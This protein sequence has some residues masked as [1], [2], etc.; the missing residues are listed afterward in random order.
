MPPSVLWKLPKIGFFIALGIACMAS[1]LR[2]METE[3]RVFDSS[4]PA[5]IRR[6]NPNQA[7]LLVVSAVLVA[8]ALITIC[9]L[10]N[11]FNNAAEIQDHIREIPQAE[12]EEQVVE[13]SS[14]STSPQ[15][16]ALAAP[17][18]PDYSNPVTYPSSYPK[19]Q[20]ITPPISQPQVAVAAPVPPPPAPAVGTQQSKKG[21][22]EADLMA[23]MGLGDDQV[24]WEPD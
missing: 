2:K 18:V 12:L 1:A 16:E 15:Q 5:I 13:E 22:T 14:H 21:F 11:D 7:L 17:I 23:A 19:L 8:D 6:D 10:V 24:A 20:P 9:S 3:G 4:Q